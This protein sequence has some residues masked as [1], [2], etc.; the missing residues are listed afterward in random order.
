MNSSTE[1]SPGMEQFLKTIKEIR[2]GVE[3]T[4]KKTNEVM[5]KKWNTKKKPEV[6]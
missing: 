1:H 3:M 5:K 2:S 6:K 4:L